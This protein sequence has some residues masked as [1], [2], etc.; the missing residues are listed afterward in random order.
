MIY[1]H[2][3]MSGNRDLS[4]FIGS[5]WINITQAIYY[6]DRPIKVHFII[7]DEVNTNRFMYVDNRW[8]QFE[9]SDDEIN[10]VRGKDIS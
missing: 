10:K 8:F 6:Y 1:T 2:L 3:F 4:N 5:S 9:L 7:N